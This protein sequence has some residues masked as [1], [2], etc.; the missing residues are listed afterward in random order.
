L[1]YPQESFYRTARD[2]FG[3]LS[4]AEN[5]ERAVQK[6]PER[7]DQRERESRTEKKQ[8]ESCLQQNIG[9]P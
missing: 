5:T 6:S 9:P 8:A 7:A 1:S 2:L 3:E 4:K